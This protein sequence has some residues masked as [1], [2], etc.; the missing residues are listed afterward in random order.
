MAI[1]KALGIITLVKHTV[2]GFQQHVL[3]KGSFHA[4]EQHLFFGER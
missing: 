4:K 1:K 3:L 2:Y